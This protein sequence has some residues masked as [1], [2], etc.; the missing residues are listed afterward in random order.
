MGLKVFDCRVELVIDFLEGLIEG[1]L[2]IRRD[3]FAVD[4]SETLHLEGSFAFGA[5]RALVVQH[6]Q[7]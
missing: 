3:D 6:A 4:I 7:V 5:Q 2:S 1:K